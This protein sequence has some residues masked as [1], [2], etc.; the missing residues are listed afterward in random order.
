MNRGGVE[1]MAQFL[2]M[3]DDAAGARAESEDRKMTSVFSWEGRDATAAEGIDS[4]RQT[5]ML[6]LSTPARAKMCATRGTAPTV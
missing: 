6:T 2:L 5:H 3:A 4:G 1:E